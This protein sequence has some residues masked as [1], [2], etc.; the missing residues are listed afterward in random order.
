MT[1]RSPKPRHRIAHRVALVFVVVLGLLLTS[2]L[3]TVRTFKRLS[4]AE[5][6]AAA[7]DVAKH[8]GHRV[9][10]LIREQYIHQAHTIISWNRSHIAH[11]KIAAED[12]REATARLLALPLTAAERVQAREIA[13]LVSRVDEDFAQAI[14]PAIDAGDRELTHDLHEE[15]ERRV[16]RVV[17]LSEGLNRKLEER[18][19]D[20][21]LE[22]ERLGRRA[23]MLVIGCFALAICVTG[24]GWVVIGRSV[25]RR[26]SELGQ[27]AL[28]LAAGDLAVRVPVRGSDEVADLASTFNEMA[29]SLA[30]HQ[31]KLVHSQRL[32]AIG[33]VA[34]GVAHEINNPLGVILG[35][36]TLLK[37]PN[38]PGD[39]LRI[40]EEEVRQCQRI[41]QG[42]LELARPSSTV[43][44]PVNLSELTRDALDRLL[45]CGKLSTRKVASPS[46]NSNLFAVGDP[47]ALRQVVTNLLEN[48]VEATTETGSIAVFV[49]EVDG[50]VELDVL[51]DGQGMM[52]DTL[53]K[54]FDPFFT[55]K[56]K[57]TGLGLAITHA[58]V[59][60]HQGSI[61]LSSQPGQGTRALVRLPRS[62]ELPGKLPIQ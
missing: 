30:S 45:E 33:Q 56:S 57:G 62:T 8:T 3:A 47:S 46:P 35:Y 38:P 17:S 22:E 58:I 40:I 14:L 12:A 34:A 11:Y 15:T 36:V 53:E 28:K 32:A 54:A 51:D 37:R 21:A 44:K 59:S 16:D 27:G 52:R 55:T 49:R 61:T 19:M 29:I 31:Q 50:A 60:A 26:L 25:L 1:P 48:A 4:A 23:A 2:L 6:E 20:A 10:G 9:A 13:H 41:V 7:L 24:V 42:L 18:A 39:G 5:R 43:T